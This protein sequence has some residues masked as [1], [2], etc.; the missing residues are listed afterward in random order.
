M[1]EVR[2]H[3]GRILPADVADAL[4]RIS[5]G[6][7]GGALEDETLDFKEDP[8][9][10]KPTADG[11][12]AKLIDMLLD[13]CVCLANGDG[14]DAHII[15]GVAD[16]VGGSVAFTGTDRDP[17]WIEQKVFNNT[18]PQLRVEVESFDWHGVG[19]L[20]IRIPLALTLY[21]RTKGQATRRVKSSCVPLDDA[22]RRSI[23]AARANPDYS[24]RAAPISFD[25]LDQMAV[26][27]ARRLFASKL[28]AMGSTE[29]PDS[30]TSG[31]LGELG[32]LTPRGELTTA[33]QILFTHLPPG[34]VGIRHL[35]RNVP[36]GEP[37][38]AEISTPL[39]LAFGEIQHR[40][41]AAVQQEVARVALNGGQEVAVPAFPQ[42]AVD[43]VVSN[44]LVH[45]DWNMVAPIVIEQSPRILTVRSP[46]PLPF[47]VSGDRLLTTQSVPRNP[48]LMAAMRMMG[49]AEESSRGFDRMWVSML[50][51]GRDV[52]EVDAS[53]I[54]VEVTISAGVPDTQFIEGV[55]RL[56]AEHGEEAIVTVR[57]LLVLWHLRHHPIMTFK[58][59]MGQ[60]QT[61]R[62]EARELMD[63]LQSQD[64][65]QRVSDSAREWVLTDHARAAMG[66]QDEPLATVSIQGW[67]EARLAD[68]GTLTSR[69]VAE[70]LGVPRADITNLLAHLR[71]LGRAIIDPDGPQ[72]GPAT[73]W[74]AP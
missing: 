47:G 4:R 20:W 3:G 67:I 35:L 41:A 73:R 10:V 48:R 28:K 24:A 69:E 43:E 11:G 37:K 22:A 42:S 64:L 36:G 38:V 56:A 29:V 12:D 70:E 68:G 19:L 13:E 62:L 49:L 2:T 50:Q 15:L 33:A 51:T 46:G 6:E 71:D 5:A 30:T 18:I 14:G 55:H 57:T 66:M 34:Q 63:W 17:Q 32:L 26:A 31:L 58:D 72:R 27:E 16:K 59:V 45:R 25:D 52:P 40:I 44:A 23:Q 9:R 74:K 1:D 65:V 39:V 54:A 21:T 61:G 53:S 60:I 7:T 8:G